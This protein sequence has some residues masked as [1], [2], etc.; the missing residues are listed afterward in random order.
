MAKQESYYFRDKRL[1]RRQRL[2]QKI[3][4]PLA[5]WVASQ[6]PKTVLVMGGMVGASWI[7]IRLLIINFY[8]FFV[9]LPWII[10]GISGVVAGLAHAL[11]GGRHE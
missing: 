2:H 9:A 3:L 10:F 11:N 4:R 1:T 5:M 6:D 8:A 7:A